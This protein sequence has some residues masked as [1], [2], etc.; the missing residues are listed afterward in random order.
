MELFFTRLR[1]GHPEPL[2]GL[3]DFPKSWK[4]YTICTERNRGSSTTLE[5]V[6]NLEASDKTHARSAYRTLLEKAQN[7]LPL[8]EQ[9]DE[10]HCHE[11]HSFDF[12]GTV[13]K[14]YRIRSGDIRIYFCYLPPSKMIVLLKTEPK[15]KDRLS[16][17]EKRELESITKAVLQYADPSDFELRVI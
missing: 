14:I 4:T 7:G 15:R 2:K 1:V 9:Y 12:N 16:K 8:P 13:V 5:D 3:E 11:A 10:K 17:S 6:R